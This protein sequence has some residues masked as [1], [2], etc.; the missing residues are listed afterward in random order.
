MKTFDSILIG[1]TL[2]VARLLRGVLTTYNRLLGPRQNRVRMPFTKCDKV[3]RLRNNKEVTDASD[4]WRTPPITI[5]ELPQR[6]IIQ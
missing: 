3:I 1:L 2:G 4:E 5:E 6:R